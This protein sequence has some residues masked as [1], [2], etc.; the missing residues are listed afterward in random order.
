MDSLPYPLGGLDR[1]ANYNVSFRV[2]R[3]LT[4]VEPA[5]ASTLDMGQFYALLQRHTNIPRTVKIDVPDV[6][7]VPSNAA[8]SSRQPHIF[9]I[10]IDSLRQDYLSPYNRSVSFTPA[11]ARFATE[12]TVFRNAFTHY[13]ATGLSEP[14]IWTGSMVPNRQYPAPF[15]P[16]NTLQKLLLAQPY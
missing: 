7:I 16:M 5:R 13:G 4:R 14:S 11:I 3:S 15:G 10:V 6:R 2:L 9:V 1:Y 8:P 12:S